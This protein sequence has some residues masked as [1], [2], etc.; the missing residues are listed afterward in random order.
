MVS[1]IDPRGRET[2][3]VYAANSID[4]LEVRRVTGP[5]TSVLGT[6]LSNYTALHRPQ[7]LT[8]AAGRATAVG[9]NAAGQVTGVTNALNQA[10]SVGYTGAYPTTVTGAV[11]GSTTTLGYDPYGRVRTITASDGYGVTLDYDHLN[12]IRKQTYP[13]GTF[14]EVVYVLPQWELIQEGCGCTG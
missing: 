6:A 11:P 7:T 2:T 4:L 1:R 10:T 13:D 9:Y 14:E 12:R 5:G 8:D 3:Y